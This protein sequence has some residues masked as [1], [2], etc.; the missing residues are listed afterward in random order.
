M[1]VWGEM[2]KNIQPEPLEPVMPEDVELVN[3]DPASGVRYDESCK[4]GVPLPFMKGSAPQAIA[5]CAAEAADAAKTVENLPVAAPPKV[6]AKVDVKPGAKAEA[7]PGV[8]PEPKAEP[9]KKNWLQR[10][11]N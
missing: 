6:E 8:K 11:F 4:G 7:K 2:M 9:E 1:T 5:P 3:I 10:L